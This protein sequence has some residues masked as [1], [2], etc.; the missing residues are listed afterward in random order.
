VHGRL[1]ISLV[2]LT[3]PWDTEAKKAKERKTARYADLKTAL[4]NEGWD[5]S[6]NLIEVGARGPYSQVGL[7]LPSVVIPGLGLCRP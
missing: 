6:L 5:F 7:G 2:E 1:R 3:C 4:R